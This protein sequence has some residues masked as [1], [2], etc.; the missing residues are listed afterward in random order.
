MSQDGSENLSQFVQRVMRQKGLSMQDVQ[1]RASKKG[2]IAPSYISRIYNGKVTNLSVDKII[3]LAEGLD[4]SPFELFAASYGAQPVVVNGIDPLRL[5]DTM[6]KAVSN[7][8]SLD[9]LEGW[10]KLSPEN[11]VKARNYIRKL[12]Q[13][14]DLRK[15]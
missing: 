10:L 11:Q 1:R 14:P 8:D 5:L 2:S 6:Q 13:K 9:V 7:P 15:P 12:S 4:V 3:V